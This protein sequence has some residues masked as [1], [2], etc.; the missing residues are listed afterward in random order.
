[1]NKVGIFYGSTTGTTT[2]I[3]E[4]I[5]ELLDADIFNVAD[6]VANAKDYDNL[7]FAASTWGM[8]DLQDDWDSALGDL[9]KID[10]NGKKFALLGVGDGVSFSSTFIDGIKKIYDSINGGELVGKV[11][12][13]GYE[14]DSSEAVVD[15]E[16]LGLA[17]DHTN[18]DDKTDDRINDWIEVLKADFI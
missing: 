13:D 16:F 7:I 11:S 15:D 18:E 4:K 5:A 9:E 17:I 14:F 2:E 12:T 3:S 8:G 1:M 6:G 10:F